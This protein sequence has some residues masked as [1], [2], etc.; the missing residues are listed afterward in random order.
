MSR[1]LSMNRSLR[2]RLPLTQTVAANDSGVSSDSASPKGRGIFGA[3]A[4]PL[5]G[6]AGRVL[7]RGRAFAAPKRLR[8]RRRVRGRFVVP[9]ALLLLLAGCSV[10]PNYHPPKT[11]APADWSEPQAGGAT[12]SPVEIIQWWKTFQDPELDALIDRA[13]TA[14]H[15]LRV[16]EARLREARALRRGAVWDLG[17][18][19]EGSAGYTEALRAKNAQAF[20]SPTLKLHTDTYD[21]HFDASWEIDIFG[22]RR[23]AL[24]SVNAEFVAVKEDRRA[25]LVSV[26]AEVARDYI[27]LRG[28]Q[29]RHAIAVKNIQAG[30]EAVAIARARFKAGL[31]GELDTA[32][33]EA[34]EA[35]TQAQ[36]PTLETAWKQAAHRLGV[37]LGQPPGALL[38]ELTTDAPVPKPPPL[39]PVGLPSDLLRRRPDVR[40]AERELAASTAAI[41]VETA[42]LF[43]KFSLIGTAGFQSLSL[44]D[45]FAP[46]GRY[47]SAGPTV[48]WRFLDFGRIRAQVKAATARQEQALAFYEKT[49]LVSFE[50]VE[51]ALV[52]Y[53]NE[54]VRYQALTAAVA[55][56]RRALELAN[57]LYT[58][59]LGQFLNVLDAERSLY[60]AE[61][62]LADSERSVSQNLVAL[63][64]A[65]G[66]GWEKETRTKVTTP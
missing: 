44:S 52:A 35:T 26:L 29:R 56:N 28:A 60:Q 13:V 1:W 12:N 34:F 62:Q 48:R 47:W 8:P 58:N 63:Y 33:A 30:A 57:S 54:Q 66:G 15:D 41:G 32:Q 5:E 46:G 61:D 27:E 49:V 43:P 18:T 6:E 21:A 25:V 7:F 51:N 17:P 9:A 42:E 19:I 45:W 10:G 53:A 23:R 36:L 59:G 2:L 20:T 55:A 50:D 11:A 22:G 38:A 24:E 64:K 65:L 14:N 37:L 16:A 31:A 4:S 39:V 3:V 40:R